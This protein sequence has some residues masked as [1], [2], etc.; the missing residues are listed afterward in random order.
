MGKLDVGANVSPS[1]VGGCVTGDKVGFLVGGIT[2]DVVGANVCH[3]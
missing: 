1:I 2:G 3:D